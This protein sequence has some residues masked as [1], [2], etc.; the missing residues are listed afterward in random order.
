MNH[1]SRVGALYNI[2]MRIPLLLVRHWLAIAI[3]RTSGG[4]G[5]KKFVG[6][7]L[8]ILSNPGGNVIG[9]L[10]E[11]QPDGR[12][13]ESNHDVGI[14]SDSPQPIPR[15]FELEGAIEGA[16]GTCTRRP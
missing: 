15:I 10:P 11:D 3:F 2:D 5:F 4:I 6:K 1:H 13:I 16:E 7:P 8:A 14:R 12:I 9:A